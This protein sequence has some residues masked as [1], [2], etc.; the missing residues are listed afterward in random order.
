MQRGTAESQSLSLREPGLHRLTGFTKANAR[1]RLRAGA[2][3]GD[4]EGFGCPHA[5]RH[6]AF[7][8][9]FVDGRY[10]TVRNR[11]VEAPSAH[12][13]CCCQTGWAAADYEHV[14]GSRKYGHHKMR[15]MRAP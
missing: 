11:D 3:Q 12:G 1:E 13:N 8:T 5:I 10:R 2:F 6:D 14:R 4:A 15:E 9:C 7:P